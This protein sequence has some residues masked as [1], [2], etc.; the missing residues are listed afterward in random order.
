VNNGRERKLL[1]SHFWKK[2]A[3]NPSFFPIDR[4]PRCADMGL[5]S[6]RSANS[7]GDVWKKRPKTRGFSNQSQVRVT[8]IFFTA[9]V[10]GV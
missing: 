8:Q 4:R 2:G 1:L 5:S 3:L 10:A 9:R 6:K 7:L